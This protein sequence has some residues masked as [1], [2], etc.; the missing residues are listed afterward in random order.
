MNSGGDDGEVQIG[1]LIS[2]KNRLDDRLA[3]IQ[4]RDYLGVYSAALARPV[5]P[6]PGSNF[7]MQ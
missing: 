4:Q 5:N 2:C 7:T 6:G 3:K 1:Q